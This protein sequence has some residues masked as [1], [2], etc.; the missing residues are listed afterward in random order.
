MCIV[1]YDTLVYYIVCYYDLHAQWSGAA[2]VTARKAMLYVYDL[3]QPAA[4]SQ[5]SQGLGF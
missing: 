5:D 2:E 4:G 3:D 1:I